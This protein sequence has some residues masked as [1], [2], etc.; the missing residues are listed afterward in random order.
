ME[1]VGFY[2]K[3]YSIKKALLAVF[4]V[5][6]F[7][8]NGMLTQAWR[9]RSQIPSRGYFGAW[10]K[11]QQ[12]EQ[13]V[14]PRNLID[15]KKALNK[16]GRRLIGKGVP[17]EGWYNVRKFFILAKNLAKNP[18]AV[19]NRYSDD[20]ISEL[21]ALNEEFQNKYTRPLREIDYNLWNVHQAINNQQR[22]MAQ[23]ELADI[24]YGRPTVKE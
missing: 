14:R 1:E 7:A 17:A 8:L 12:P 24:A 22:N 11:P 3:K 15:E 23:K 4:L 9:T 10:S 5:S 16:E 21:K 13:Q 6:P 2:M 20:D 19:W 18:G